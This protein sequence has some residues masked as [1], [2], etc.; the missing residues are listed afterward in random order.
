MQATGTQTRM[1]YI[2]FGCTTAA[3]RVRFQDPKN[4]VISG[5]LTAFQSKSVKKKITNAAI[6]KRAPRHQTTGDH[7]AE[8]RALR[9]RRR[10]QLM[11]EQKGI[12][13]TRRELKR[14]QAKSARLGID[15]DAEGEV[16]NGEEFE[17]TLHPDDPMSSDSSED[18]VDEGE[19]EVE[20]D[21]LDD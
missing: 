7:F 11:R 13:K 2:H 9:R 19:D 14:Q 1:S 8:A 15:A 3:Q 17:Y 12:K 6:P 5:S 4:V 16:D 20:E 18:E 21:E 10:E